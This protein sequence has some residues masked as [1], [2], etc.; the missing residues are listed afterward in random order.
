GI[1][2]RQSLVEWFANLDILTS[3]RRP[4][5]ARDCWLVAYSLHRIRLGSKQLLPLSNYAAAQQAEVDI[6]T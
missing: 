3:K 2:E 1:V 4:T 5:V 6:F